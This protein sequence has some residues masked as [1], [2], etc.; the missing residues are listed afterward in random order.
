[1]SVYALPRCHTAS[2]AVARSIEMVVDTNLCIHFLLL[3]TTCEICNFYRD[4]S[5]IS[6]STNQVPRLSYETITSWILIGHGARLEPCV[7]IFLTRMTF[8]TN[9]RN[10]WKQLPSYLILADLVNS[11]CHTFTREYFLNFRKK[12]FSIYTRLS[13]SRVVASGALRKYNIFVIFLQFRVFV[14][15]E[16]HFLARTKSVEL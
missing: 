2:R 8:K 9:F 4:S 6:I 13:F 10:S 3:S 12:C 15:E 14:V 16:L 7:T 11:H 5:I 1:M